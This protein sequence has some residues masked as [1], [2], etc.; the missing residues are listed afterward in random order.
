MEIIPIGRYRNSFSIRVSVAQH[1]TNPDDAGISPQT[2]CLPP[3]AIHLRHP[4]G[5]SNPCLVLD[6]SAGEW[7]HPPLCIRIQ[8]SHHGECLA[9]ALRGLDAPGENLKLMPLACP[10]M[11]CFNECAI[12]PH[13]H[14]LGRFRDN[15]RMIDFISG[16]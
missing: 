15:T 5:F 8:V 9:A 1:G 10:S 13:Y 14:S 12:D 6:R 11:P 2:R 16:F 3:L 4:T 7:M